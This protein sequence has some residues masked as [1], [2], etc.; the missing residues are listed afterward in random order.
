[1]STSRL[2]RAKNLDRY[3]SVELLAHSSN[4]IS[5]KDQETEQIHS[6]PVISY[7]PYENQLVHKGVFEYGIP[8]RKQNVVFREAEFEYRTASGL[9]LI[10][11]S[12]DQVDPDKIISEINDSVS[13]DA[14]ISGSVQI[15]RSHL[16]DFLNG[17]RSIEELKLSSEDGVYDVSDLLRVMKADDSEEELDLI[18]REREESIETLR[19]L[20][21]RLSPGKEVESLHDLDLD[22]YSINIINAEATFWYGDKPAT[23]TYQN[24]LIWVDANNENAREYVIQLFER[25]VVSPSYDN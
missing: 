25:D 5:I 15:S 7:Y 16:W 18:E 8:G 21:T 1:M 10:S 6:L 4:Q 9:F 11:T 19:K 24:G 13:S 3:W 20:T 2:G 14:Q 23:L 17:A 12:V 22:L